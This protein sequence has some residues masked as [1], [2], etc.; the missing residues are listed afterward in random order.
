MLSNIIRIAFFITVSTIFIGCCINKSRYNKILGGIYIEH[1][2]SSNLASNRYTIDNKVYKGGNQYTYNFYYEDLDKKK[3][4]FKEIEGAS[5]LPFLER[6]KAWTL[7][8][9]ENI[10]S[11]VIEQV[12]LTI[13]YDL[14][15]KPSKASNYSQTV[16]AYDYPQKNR[17]QKFSE[18][19]G[20]IE[21]TKNIWMH[22]PRKKLFR[23][24]ELNP[25]PFIQT[26]YKV[27]NKWSWTLKIGSFW[28]DNR[29]R[30]WDQS[31]TNQYNYEITAIKKIASKFGNLR[32][33]EIKSTA[34]SE[35]GKTSLI[36]YFNLKY[37]FVKLNYTNIDS[38]KMLFE[39]VKVNKG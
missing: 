26:P 23:I 17:K 31:I 27:G 22:P 9:K 7:V 34:Q 28:G 10:D 33:Y 12:Y 32:C 21:N 19:T 6:V 30:T 1:I 37:G 5:K 16:I 24:L 15:E 36:A 29:W 18:R 20:L 11:N 35:L 4:V 2:D 14:K 25:F 39:L 3:Y 13:K 8:P 38:T